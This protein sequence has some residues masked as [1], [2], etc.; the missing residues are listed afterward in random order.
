MPADIATAD[1]P[2]ALAYGVAAAIALMKRIQLH[3]RCELSG[4]AC[5]E[6]AASCACACE[7]TEAIANEF[8]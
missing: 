2:T 5:Q 4:E 3:N 7:T 8:D 1:E 6:N